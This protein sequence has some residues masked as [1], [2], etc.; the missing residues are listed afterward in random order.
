MPSVLNTLFSV[1]SQKYSIP[2]YDPDHPSPSLAYHQSVSRSRSTKSTRSRTSSLL[3]NTGIGKDWREEPTLP[4]AESLR[5]RNEDVLGVGYSG[6]GNGHVRQRTV[7]LGSVKTVKSAPGSVKREGKKSSSNRTSFLSSGS[8]MF[9]PPPIPPVPKGYESTTSSSAG[10]PSV[11]TPSAKRH[12]TLDFDRRRATPSP[13]HSSFSST[14]APAHSHSRSHSQSTNHSQ[15]TSNAR[16]GYSRDDYS[17]ASSISAASSSTGKVSWSKRLTGAPSRKY[18]TSEPEV[19]QVDVT[20]VRKG[21][22]GKERESV[23]W[24]GEEYESLDGHAATRWLD[25]GEGE[26]KRKKS[27]RKSTKSVSKALPPEPPLPQ[28]SSAKTITRT[29]AE[30]APV[31]SPSAIPGPALPPE[32]PEPPATEMELKILRALTRTGLLDQVLEAVKEEESEADR[33]SKLPPSP[34]VVTP[35]LVKE[36]PDVVPPPAWLVPASSTPAVPAVDVQNEIP[37]I[38]E[39]IVAMEEP[40]MK[41][42]IDLVPSR[43]MKE[44]THVHLSSL[45]FSLP[46]SLAGTIS[47]LNIFFEKSVVLLYSFDGWKTNGTLEGRWQKSAEDGKLDVFGFSGEVEEEGEVE[48]KAVFKANGEE[49]MDDD[50]LVFWIGDVGGSEKGKKKAQEM[51]VPK[52]EEKK[53]GNTLKIPRLKLTRTKSDQE[54]LGLVED[55]L[56]PNTP[57]MPA[58][59]LATT[60]DSPTR[61]EEPSPVPPP[62]ART[63]PIPP[64]QP[65]FPAPVRELSYPP[66]TSEAKHDRPSSVELHQ[67]APLRPSAN[68]KDQNNEHVRQSVLLRNH[69]SSPRGSIETTTDSVFTRFG[70]GNAPSGLTSL[71][72]TV[73][74]LPPANLKRLGPGGNIGR[75]AQSVFSEDGAAPSLSNFSTMTAPTGM[76][77]A[78]KNRSRAS[79]LGQDLQHESTTIGTISVCANVLLRPSLLQR[80]TNSTPKRLATKLIDPS[81]VLGYGSLNRPPKKLGADQILV[82][83]WAVGINSL[84]IDIARQVIG[85]GDAFGWIPGRSFIGRAIEH[86]YEVGHA[87]RGEVVMGLMDQNKS[88]ACAELI[89]VD[90]DRVAPAPEV[91]LNTEEIALLPLYGVPAFQIAI[92][93]STNLPN[94]SK[95]LILNAHQGIGFLTLQLLRT[96]RSGVL[97]ITAQAP[98][99]TGESLEFLHAVGSDLSLNQPLDAIALIP[100]SSFDVVIDTVGGA[101]VYHASRRILHGDGGSFITTVGDSTELPTV[102]AQWRTG[103]KSWKSR[104]F[105]KDNKRISYWC[106][107]M[108]ERDDCKESL[109][110]LRNLAVK[111]EIKPPVGRVVQFERGETAFSDDMADNGVVIRLV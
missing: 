58:P 95:I 22:K 15:S 40:I 98:S 105:K 46:R 8:D 74:N 90:G 80:L 92:S 4:N 103:V 101:D 65:V 51:E 104:F 68:P 21:R 25:D 35:S 37:Q 93:L 7:S 36:S 59:A 102:G 91:R 29:S 28:S 48:L 81:R 17:A 79:F 3:S 14:S 109:V 12:S 32:R 9:I 2:L 84:D 107:R 85:K 49:W 42:K 73:E 5:L 52:E 82:Q 55:E 76:Y 33:T 83:V 72:T 100:D 54:R 1:P 39:A 61:T 70:N 11:I 34:P 89:I 44:G 96:M 69:S 47:V 64:P 66:P 16:R 88:G 53:D 30:A 78:P 31:T 63:N 94:G 86:G 97:W 110:E 60:I 19:L 27:K 20:R 18:A 38:E 75:R 41:P 43:P 71:S 57:P 45:S 67:P 10:H 87:R 106:V 62:R 26:R 50:G 108:D 13:T 56:I 99:H 111:G 23:A 24:P 77:R 6:N